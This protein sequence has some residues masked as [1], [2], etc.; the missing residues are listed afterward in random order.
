MP[1]RV[2]YQTEML[3]LEQRH[4]NSDSQIGY[5]QKMTSKAVTAHRYPGQNSRLTMWQTLYENWG[6]ECWA[7][8][9]RTQYVI[10]ISEASTTRWYRLGASATLDRTA[11]G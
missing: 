3:F 5:T 1:L 7:Y 4:N 2:E 6:Q 11:N 8:E 10:R 9:Q